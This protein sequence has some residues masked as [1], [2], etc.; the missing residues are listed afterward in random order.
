MFLAA[1]SKGR[2]QTRKQFQTSSSWKSLISRCRL[3]CLVARLQPQTICQAN[4]IGNEVK[5]AGRDVSFTMPRYRGMPSTARRGG[6]VGSPAK[7]F[8]G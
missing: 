7:D 6:R 5:P 3:V 8:G 1:K 2:F 4:L